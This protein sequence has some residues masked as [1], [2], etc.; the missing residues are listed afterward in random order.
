MMNSLNQQ[1]NNLRLNVSFLIECSLN[2]SATIQSNLKTYPRSNAFPIKGN[3]VF[4][5]NDHE[6][7]LFIFLKARFSKFSFVCF[8]KAGYL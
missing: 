3:Y 4:S 6:I 7:Y 5:L 1:Q 2:V 8:L